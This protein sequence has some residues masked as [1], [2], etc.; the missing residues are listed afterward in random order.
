M[1]VYDSVAGAYVVGSNT[2][3]LVTSQNTFESVSVCADATAGVRIIIVKKHPSVSWLASHFSWQ[4][5][6]QARYRIFVLIYY[7]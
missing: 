3:A 7:V 5:G 6:K 4:I 1:D 2:T